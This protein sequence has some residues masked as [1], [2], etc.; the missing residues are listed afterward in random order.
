MFVHFSSRCGRETI[1]FTFLY[2]LFSSFCFSAARQ[3]FQQ[4]ARGNCV[5]D[6][7]KEG[8]GIIAYIICDAVD[9]S[10]LSYF[11]SAFKT[12]DWSSGKCVEVRHQ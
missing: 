10:K 11:K 3:D 6:I 7:K 9:I 12:L 1:H 2:L 5:F 4:T 8:E